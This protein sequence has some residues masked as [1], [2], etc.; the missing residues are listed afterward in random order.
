MTSYELVPFNITYSILLFPWELIRTACVKVP[1]CY[2]RK[3]KELDA[4]PE[5]GGVYTNHPK[6][7]PY[8]VRFTLSMVWGQFTR[9]VSLVKTI[10]YSAL[11][12]DVPGNGGDI[13][14]QSNQTDSSS[15]CGPSLVPF[16]NAKSFIF[17]NNCER[18][19]ILPHLFSNRAFTQSP[20][21]LFLFSCAFAWL[22]QRCGQQSTEIEIVKIRN[23][24]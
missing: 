12:D 9:V 21:C 10:I 11:M 14:F 23:G 2:T 20:N 3:T 5:A 8:A 22:V 1:M 24:T 7:T 19:G 13:I 15:D 6:S 18:W 4:A 16:F 17:L